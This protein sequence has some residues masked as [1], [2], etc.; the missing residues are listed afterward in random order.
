MRTAIG[1]IFILAISS[2]K[3]QE[4]RCTVTMN[5][6]GQ[7]VAGIDDRIFQTLKNTVTEFMNQR[8]WTAD[9]YAPEEKIECNLAITISNLISQ[10]NYEATVAIQSSRP[11]YQSNYNSPVFSYIDNDW[12]F[13]YVENQPIDFNVNTYTSSLSSLLA[14]YAYMIIGYDLETM[15]KNG[16]QKCFQQCETI[17]NNIPSQGS[18]SKGWKPY[19]GI[20]N[21][22]HI[23]NQLMSS[24]YGSF[25]NALY[26]YHYSGL[27][28]FYEKP[29]LA[30][31]N[32]LNA[33]EKLDKIARDNPNATLLTTFTAAKSDELVGI[34]SQGDM[35]EKT[36]ALGFL[37]RID[38]V[39]S[40]KYDKIIRN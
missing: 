25:R 35:N 39:N 29:A 27:D 10:D 2:A 40:S 13:G 37:R 7:K 6:N 26:E 21:R 20:R 5:V 3:A 4:L 11:I 9:Q 23:I 1:I 18:D 28:Q 22:Y 31:Q 33:L 32:V 24:R 30:R 16:G 8:A 15:G 19:D 34:F 38:P 36:K 12:S 17:L 14:F